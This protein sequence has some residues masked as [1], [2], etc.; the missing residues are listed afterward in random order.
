MI[1]QSLDGT[2]IA[3]LPQ[4]LLGE[5]RATMKVS[6]KHVA[7]PEKSEVIY[8]CLKCSYV[9]EEGWS[10]VPPTFCPNCAINHLKGEIVSVMQPLDY[11]K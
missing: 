4:V 2:E 5:H 3:N 8:K 6:K 10:D 7:A 11:K 1:Q 9:F